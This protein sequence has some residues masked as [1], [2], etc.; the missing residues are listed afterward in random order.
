MFLPK[1]RAFNVG[2]NEWEWGFRYST[3]GPLQRPRHAGSG[4]LVS[5][6][7]LRET[8]T[9]GPVTEQP[10]PVD[11]D[12]LAAKRTSLETGTPK[13][14][15]N[16]LYNKVALQF[17]NRRDNHD[18]RPAQWSAGVE[19]LPERHEF[20]TKMVQRIEHF[21]KV[22]HAASQT[23]GGPHDQGVELPAV[24]S[25]VQALKSP[26]R[27]DAYIGVRGRTR[28]IELNARNLVRKEG[29]VHSE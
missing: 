5:L 8:Q 14:G 20:D 16:P 21:Q 13:S 3:V 19:V 6:G 27:W 7:Q 10:H 2:W 22:P 1:R 28:S 9:A 17:R 29:H 18:N 23:V 24:G 26:G 25:A 12:G 4:N 11:L 15:A